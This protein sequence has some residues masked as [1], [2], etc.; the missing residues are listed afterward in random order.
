MKKTKNPISPERAKVLALNAK[1]SKE[2]RREASS[3]N[4]VKKLGAHLVLYPLP[5]S[6]KQIDEIVHAAGGLPTVGEPD[7]D[8]QKALLGEKLAVLYQNLLMKR[9]S[10]S[11]PSASSGRKRFDRVE[12]LCSQLLETLEIQDDD[13]LSMPHEIKFLIHPAANR[14]ALAVGG[15][16]DFPP[17]DSS[18]RGKEKCQQVI[19]GIVLM[20]EWAKDEQ[21]R[22]QSVIDE[23]K[24]KGKP[25]HSRDEAMQEFFGGLNGVWIN[26][27][28]EIPGMTF[29][30][31]DGMIKGR[32]FNFVQAIFAA[33]RENVT[34]EMK[35]SDSSLFA[36][37]NLSDQAIRSRFRDTGISKIQKFF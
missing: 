17:Q 3:A 23:H 35:V 22:A 32:F 18:F 25:N 14:Y 10:Q 26:W 8:Q 30:P 19:D 15:Y 7:I 16:A 2:R 24:S 12:R 27:F 21:Q 33:M 11:L 20:R 37:L 1:N 13:P 28:G 31:I 5:F 4:K 34:A 29:D 9:F 6:T 36:Y